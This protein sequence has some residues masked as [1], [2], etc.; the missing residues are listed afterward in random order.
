MLSITSRN[1]YGG[2]ITLSAGIADVSRITGVKVTEMSET[3]GLGAHCQDPEWI[4]QFTGIDAETVRFTKTGKSASN[5]I[6]AISGATV[7]TTAVTDAVNEGLAFART[8]PWE[9]SEK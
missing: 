6:D 3:S 2:D 7:T 8:L 1:G 9:G 4:G 5:E